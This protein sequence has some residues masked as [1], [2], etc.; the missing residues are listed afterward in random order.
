MACYA[1]DVP[2]IFSVEGQEIRS[3]PAISR[4]EGI[5]RWTSD[6]KGLLIWNIGTP[7][8]LDRMD[9]VTGQ[10]TTIREIKTSGQA[11]VVSMS[12]C[13]TTSDA[14]SYI[15]S[16]HRALIDLFVTTGLK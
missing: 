12:P 8:R 7:V 1:A 15:C 16:E 2:K 3:L 10:R 4:R 5:D 14:K 11:G 9:V 6:G 13:R